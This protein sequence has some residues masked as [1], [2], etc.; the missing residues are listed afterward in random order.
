[1]KVQHLF[2]YFLLLWAALCCKTAELSTPKSTEKAITAN[3]SVDGLAGATVSFDATTFT[4]TINVS[5]STD[6]KALKLSIPIS[7]GATI[8]PDPATARDYTN[9]VQYTITAEDGSKQ[10]Y[11]VQVVKAAGLLP[12]A[13]FTVQN[14]GCTASCTINFTNTST[15]ASSYTWTFGD[16]TQATTPNA[17]KQYTTSG[18]YTVTLRATGVGGTATSQQI[19]SVLGSATAS[20]PT[21]VWDKSFG[22]SSNQIMNSMIATSDG[23]FLLGGTSE[24]PVSGNKTATNYGSSDFWVVKINA[25]GDKVWDKAFG[26]SGED[27]LTSMI[28][29][30]DGGFL[31][32]GRSGSPVS[33]SKTAP[34]YGSFDYWVVKINANGDK[35]WDKTFGGLGDDRMSSMIAT[36]DGGFLLAGAS[37]SSISGNKTTP[38]YSDEDYWVVKINANGD[39]V[40]DKT[41]GGSG[42]DRLYSIIAT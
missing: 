3:P 18:S 20:G 24:S 27:E 21:Q 28:A 4:Y 8:S 9:P 11:T 5:A 10:V 23:G 36:S 42:D 2:L 33:G 13:S 26:G 31:L 35:V 29:T 39:K 15:N 34:N 30:S 32:G 17:T 41:F 16:G 19:V 1:M 22:G 25:N 12:T 6:V 37:Y 38:N 14:N 40:W 7:A